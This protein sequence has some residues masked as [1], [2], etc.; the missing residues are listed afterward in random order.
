[1]SYVRLPL[2][3]SRSCLLGQCLMQPL[4]CNFIS[5]S[6]KC[7]TKLEVMCRH[8]HSC[9][10]GR[11]ASYQ[12][13]KTLLIVLFNGN[14]IHELIREFIRSCTV[15]LQLLLML[16]AMHYTKHKLNHE[17]MTSAQINCTADQHL[18]FCYIV[19]TIPLPPEI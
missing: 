15:N 17:Y 7:A 16:L 12:T 2:H 5:M 4:R 9:L 6:G 14:I 10:L 3:I 18:C 13:N 19:N 1:M 8:E 11:K